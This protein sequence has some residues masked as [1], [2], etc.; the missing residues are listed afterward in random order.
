MDFL[1]F[2]QLPF[3]Y[4]LP[5]I[6]LTMFLFMSLVTSRSPLVRRRKFFQSVSAVNRLAT[7]MEPIGKSPNLGLCKFEGDANAASLPQ[8]RR[9][10]PSA[11]G[12][13]HGK[14]IWQRAAV[15]AGPI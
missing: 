11:A 9:R 15:A 3:G 1:N 10:R 14:P 4:L 5:F 8:A 6:A 13:F 12:D 7:G 2:I